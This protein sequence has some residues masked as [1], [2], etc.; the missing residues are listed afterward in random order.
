MS[1]LMLDVGQ[2]NEL[3]L[4]FRRANYT[5]DDIKRLCEGNVLADVRT[6]LLG[7]T[8]RYICLTV[9]MG[10]HVIDCNADPIRS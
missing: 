5:N 1:D 3:K 7:R 9:K 8:E 4:A 6:V 2:A 10:E